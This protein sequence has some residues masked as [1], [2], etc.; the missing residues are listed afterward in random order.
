M[1]PRPR[2]SPVSRRSDTQ[3]E[4]NSTRV[5][6]SLNPSIAG[7]SFIVTTRVLRA[8]LPRV[9]DDAGYNKGSSLKVGGQLFG[10][11]K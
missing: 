5:A 8:G 11:M 7:H 2:N 3:R 1:T 9:R 10:P 6:A 4:S